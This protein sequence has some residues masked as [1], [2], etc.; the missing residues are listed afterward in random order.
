MCK[1]NYRVVVCKLCANLINEIHFR[2]LKA[3]NIEGCLN[4][5]LTDKRKCNNISIV[6][7]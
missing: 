2:S 5:S 4:K 3:T 7:T 6:V 1:I